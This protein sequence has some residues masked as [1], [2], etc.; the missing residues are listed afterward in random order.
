MRRT[1]APHPGRVHDRLW[2]ALTFLVMLSLLQALAALF[3]STF[4]THD[5][6]RLLLHYGALLGAVVLR[7]RLIAAYFRN[8]PSTRSCSRSSNQICRAPPRATGG[9][10]IEQGDPQTFFA[11]PKSDRTRQFLSKI[12]TH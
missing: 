10:V 5:I 1:R 12:L 11:A 8:K 9:S 4:G 3:T 7:Q 6:R 2:F